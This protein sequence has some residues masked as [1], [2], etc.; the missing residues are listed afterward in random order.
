MT[1]MAPKQNMPTNSLKDKMPVYQPQKYET[2]PVTQ[3]SSQPEDKENQYQP[4][5][6]RTPQNPVTKAAETIG[7]PQKTHK[8]IASNVML[9]SAISSAIEMI[10]AAKSSAK[11]QPKEARTPERPQYL[12]KSNSNDEEA[13]GKSTP[14]WN[15]TNESYV[16]PIAQKTATNTT[17]EPPQNLDLSKPTAASLHKQKA[18]VINGGANPNIV[19]KT[20][21]KMTA[22]FKPNKP[23]VAQSSSAVVSKRSNP[24]KAKPTSAS[25]TEAMASR[26][27]TA[28][29]TPKPLNTSR[30]GKSYMNS[31]I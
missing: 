7:E 28:N 4:K 10:Q 22:A 17:P 20:L 6:S 24:V 18:P 30:T 23:V 25:S 29:G 8:E 15:E 12:Q 27:N 16:T 21:A 11:P 5:Q 2:K 31:V 13:K 14:L 9:D 26:V 1:N 19:K 3:T